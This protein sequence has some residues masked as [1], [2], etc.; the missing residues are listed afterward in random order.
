MAAVDVGAVLEPPA[1]ALTTLWRPAASAAVADRH[2]AELPVIAGAGARRALGPA[3]PCKSN[4]KVDVDVGVG[5][6]RSANLR[7]YFFG[8]GAGGRGCS[9]SYI[10]SVDRS[11]AL[12][13]SIAI[14][15]ARP[16]PNAA[17]PELRIVGVADAPKAAARW[18]S[19]KSGG[20]R[21]RRHHG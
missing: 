18:R 15:S 10:R 14:R 17:E 8:L 7:I 20:A 3:R 2:E 21:R 6:S 13:V 11:A 12:V 5:R 19:G 4:Y 16:R 1:T 9:S